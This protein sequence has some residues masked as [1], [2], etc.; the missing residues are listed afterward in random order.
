MDSI[1][2][3]TAEY[4]PEICEL[5]SNYFIWEKTDTDY[6]KCKKFIYHVNMNHKNNWINKSRLATY[7]FEPS[8]AKQLKMFHSLRQRNNFYQQYIFSNWKCQNKT[9]LKP[10]DHTCWVFIFLFTNFIHVNLNTLFQ[11]QLFFLSLCLLFFIKFL[12]FIKW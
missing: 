8:S 9:D 12:F 4:W 10:L 7:K 2:V 1:K 3:S 11:I 5:R 6:L